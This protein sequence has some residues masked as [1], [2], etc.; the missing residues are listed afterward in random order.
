ML[1]VT[2]IIQRVS[3]ADRFVCVCVCVFESVYNKSCQVHLIHSDTHEGVNTPPQSPDIPAVVIFSKPVFPGLVWQIADVPSTSWFLLCFSYQG[4]PSHLTRL[5][6][7]RPII[8]S[9]RE[10]REWQ[11]TLQALTHCSLCVASIP[12]SVFVRISMNE[13]SCFGLCGEE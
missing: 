10:Q 5:A 2:K 8:T 7:A 13:E 12:F 4:P 1:C 9:E 11:I 3:D 6:E